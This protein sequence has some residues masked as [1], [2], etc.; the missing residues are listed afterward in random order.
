MMRLNRVLSCVLLLA[1]AV[2]NGEDTSPPA[3]SSMSTTTDNANAV[4]DLDLTLSK[5][6]E[7][8]LGLPLLDGE[9]EGVSEDGLSGFQAQSPLVL[10]G[11]FAQ[12]EAR[13]TAFHP[14]STHDEDI[15]GLVGKFMHVY[16]SEIDVTNLNAEVL[17]VLKAEVR[18]HS[19]AS[20]SHPVC[21]LTK[22]I[23]TNHL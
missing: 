10:T 17:H 12:E 20:G 14:A 6:L 3:N 19:T 16:Q 21:F 4:E 9:A 23:L 18:S 15:Q 8:L 11:A 1:F 22:S 5:E 13:A 7:E 2:A